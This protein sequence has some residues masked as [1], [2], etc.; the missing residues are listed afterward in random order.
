MNRRNFYII[1]ILLSILKFSADA[2]DFS[3]RSKIDSLLYRLPQ[4]NPDE[5][6]TILLE[7]S[8]KYMTLSLESSKEYALL[9]LTNAKKLKDQTS[10]ADAYKTIGNIYFQQGFN[11][12]VIAYYDSSLYIYTTLNDSAGMAKV[13]NNLGII[14]Q[15]VGVYEQSIDYHIKSLNYKTNIHDTSGIISSVNNIGSIYYDLNEFT[16]SEEYFLKALEL[17]VNF[18]YKN[19]HSILNNLGLICQELGNYNKSIEYLDQALAE[20]KKSNDRHGTATSLHNLGKSY[21][22]MGEFQKA[23]NQYFLAIKIYDEIGIEKSQTLNNIG[24]IYI[25]LDYYKKALEY[26]YEALEIAKKNNQFVNLRDIYNNISVAYERLGQYQNAYENYVLFNGYDDSIR[27]QM[28]SNRIENIYQQANIDRKRKELET[29]NLET[30][31]ILEKK[32]SAI[33]RKNFLIYSFIGGIAA[34][35]ALAIVLLNM[36]RHKTKANKLLKV[37]N[38]EIIRSDNIIKKINKALTQNEE[39]LRSIFDASPSAIVVINPETLVLDCNNASLKMFGATNKREIINKNINQLFVSD[40]LKQAQ[41]NIKNAFQGVVIEKQEFTLARKDGSSFIAEISGGMIK[42]SAGK[43]SAYV[44]IITDITER[45]HFI[46][47]LNQAKLEAEESDRLKTAFLANMSHEIRTP[48]NSIIG[49]SNLLNEPEMR[50]D[51]REEYLQHILQSSNLLLNLI[52][53]I[54]DISKIEAGQININ[55]VECKVNLLVRDLFNSIKESNAKNGIEFKLNLP[56]DSDLYS[57]R[58]DPFRLKQILF[59][60]IGNAIKFTEKGFIE[61]GYTIKKNDTKQMIEFYLRDSGIGIP[62]EKQSIIFERFRQVDDSRTRRFGGTGLGLAISK[63]LVDLLGGT[64]WVE[65]II[66]KG[67]TFYFSLPFESGVREEIIQPEQFNGIKYNWKGKTILI[68]EDENSNFELLK[69]SIGRTQIKIIRAMNGEEAVEHVKKNQSIDLVLMDIRMPKLN[70]YDATRQ[71]KIINPKLPVISIT[72][73]AMSEDE[74]KSLEAGCD[75]YI[76]KPIRPSNLL[77]LLNEFISS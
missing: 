64:I 47:N 19:Y 2:A 21:F 25:E 28:Y 27:N 45:L 9:A 52:D 46:E 58:T 6:T 63:R 70:G 49:F 48:M 40:Q 54:I 72:A 12:E 61:L 75:M 43:Y 7:L 23:L 66:D 22:M 74:T 16:K 3:D 56:P 11:N 68:A 13:W 71:M 38:E 24:Q 59:N 31:L 4:A 67:S 26:L 73:Y 32:D 55:P 60:L 30:Q 10:M 50:Q 57:F 8:K 65:S 39:M 33:R 35:L 53:D 14:Y 76:S 37:Q 18:H 1:F 77:Y 62:K 51:K 5:K 29:L 44:M 42:D 20:S 36:F 34:V 17:S 15:H 69:A 41:E